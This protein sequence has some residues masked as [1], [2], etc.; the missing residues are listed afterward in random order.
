MIV[1]SWLSQRKL[2]TFVMDATKNMA[3]PNIIGEISKGS[4]DI[5]DPI[6]KKKKK[7]KIPLI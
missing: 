4:S 7:K 2:Q 3:L 6:G 5:K 1:S